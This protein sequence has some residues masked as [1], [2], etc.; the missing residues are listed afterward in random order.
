MS[1]LSATSKVAVKYLTEGV[2]MSLIYEA[3]LVPTKSDVIAA[4]LPSQEW[5]NGDASKLEIITGYRFDDPEGEVGIQGQLVTAD[6]GTL[7][8]V[9]LTYRGAPLK[10]A[11]NHLM[12]TMQHSVLGKRWVYD[13][14]GDPVF[15][16]VLAN[17]IAKGGSQAE[18]FTAQ[19]DGTTVPRAVQSYVNGSGS[20]ENSTP[21]LEAAKVSTD[22]GV[23]SAK[24]RKVTLSILR[25]IDS[26]TTFTGEV[27]T[28]QGTWDGQEEPVVL[29]TLQ[30]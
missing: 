21:S 13:A 9:P 23:S 24:D 16:T 1:I 19:P 25:R 5:F 26:R 7:Y 11:E 18:E 3:E 22:D 28:L 14:I 10:G 2:Q 17:V 27:E 30:S 4:W 29:A 20:T 15:Q 8:H 6:D 12:G